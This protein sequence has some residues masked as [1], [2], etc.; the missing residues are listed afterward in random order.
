[1]QSTSLVVLFVMCNRELSYSQDISAKRSLL[2]LSG[3]EVM[4]SIP[5]ELR[6]QKD[7]NIQFNRLPIL[8]GALWRYQTCIPNHLT[9]L[10]LW[11][12]TFILAIHPQSYIYYRIVTKPR[13]SI[14]GTWFCLS[15]SPIKLPTHV[16]EEVTAVTQFQLSLIFPPQ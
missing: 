3:C 4:G 8:K 10:N 11:C 16:S 9:K 1:M 12:I 7:L 2:R 14:I 5:E 13:F 6:N 15:E